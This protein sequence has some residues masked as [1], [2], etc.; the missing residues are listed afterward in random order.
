MWQVF[1]YLANERQVRERQDARVNRRARRWTLGRRDTRAR[2]TRT[3]GR[4]TDP[5]VS[6]RV[7]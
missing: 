5:R 4:V 7:H 6:T 2:V 3:E 1:L